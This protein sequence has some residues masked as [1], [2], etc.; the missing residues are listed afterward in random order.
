MHA[1]AHPFEI[2]RGRN[3]DVRESTRQLRVLDVGAARSRCRDG[4]ADLGEQLISAERRREQLAEELV[5]RNRAPTPGTDGNHRCAEGEDH[6][7]KIRRWIRVRE[8]PADR[9]TVTNLWIT[10]LGGGV[11]DA[12]RGVANIAACGELGMR[13]HR[14]DDERAAVA[15]DSLE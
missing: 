5:R 1:L 8:T 4:D 11:G 12:R 13:R 15:P 6:R 3:A 7:G 9:A 14:A 2:D 10:D